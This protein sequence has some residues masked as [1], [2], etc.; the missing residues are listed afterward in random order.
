MKSRYCAI[1]GKITYASFVCSN[2]SYLRIARLMYFHYSK[3]TV[4]RR[5]IFIMRTIS[6]TLIE[7][8]YSPVSRACVHGMLV[9]SGSLFLVIASKIAIPVPFSPVPV[10]GQTW[11]ILVL[12]GLLG[13]VHATSAVMAY[14]AQGLAGLPVFAGPGAG[15]AYLFGP[16]GGY[17]LGFIAAAWIAG[18]AHT[19]NA[20][21]GIIRCISLLTA[22]HVTI[23][24]AG[25]AWLSIMV[26][27]SR[28]VTMG[29]LPFL[30]GD[31]CKIAL[32]AALVCGS[33]YIRR[34]SK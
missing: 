8:T 26:G 30:A 4:T 15:P 34:K 6:R 25:T 2:I 10:T 16:T 20:P 21:G 32:A 29:I 31:I 18:H 12:G 7:R 33:G 9:V 11:A 23:Y 27:L 1:Q 5:S 13:P 3:K 19:R 14:L 24:A 22:A 17:L 28:A